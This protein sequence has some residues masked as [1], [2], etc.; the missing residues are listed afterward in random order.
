MSFHVT[1]GEALLLDLAK[2]LLKL[3]Y[4]ISLLAVLVPP[5]LLGVQHPDLG[6]HRLGRAPRFLLWGPCNT[7]RVL[8]FWGLIFRPPEFWKLA[9]QQIPQRNVV[10]IVGTHCVLPKRLLI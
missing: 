4:L 8:Y 7:V 6:S 2:H 3:R 9:Y 1:L 5:T 10:G